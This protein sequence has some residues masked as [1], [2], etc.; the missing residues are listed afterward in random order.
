MP[1]PTWNL[2]DH[3]LQNWDAAEKDN[4]RNFA[5]R[6]TPLLKIPFGQL[7]GFPAASFE[8]CICIYEVSSGVW[9]PIFSDGTNWKKITLGATVP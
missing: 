9:E 4:W 7:G 8:Q 5:E 6:P 1:R 3:G 2:P